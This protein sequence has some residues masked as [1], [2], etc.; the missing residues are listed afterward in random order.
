MIMA[1]ALSAGVMFSAQARAQSVGFVDMVKLEQKMTAYSVISCL[2][3]TFPP[4][5]WPSFR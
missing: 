3:C 2:P 1:V 4:L 5:R